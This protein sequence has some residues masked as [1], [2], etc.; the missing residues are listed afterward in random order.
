MPSQAPIPDGTPADISSLPTITYAGY[1]LWHTQRSFIYNRLI[2]AGIMYLILDFL[3]VFMTKDPYFI[4]GPDHP[5]LPHLPL[6]GYLQGLHPFF[7]RVYRQVFSLAGVLSAISGLFNLNDLAQYFL[8]SYI[9]PH[10]GDLWQHSS[11]FGSFHLVFDRGLAGWWGG[12]WHQ[13]FRA[14]FVAPAKWLVKQGYLES[15]S[16]AASVVALVVSFGQSGL[17]H[18][19]GSI[20]SVAE[21]KIW[22]SPLFFAL[23]TLGII[24]QT[25][26]AWFV[27]ERLHVSVPRRLAQA[28]NLAFTLTWLY[29]TADLFINDMA[30]AGIWLLEPVPF[31]FVRMC[32]FGF[33]GDRWWRWDEYHRPSWYTAQHWWQSGIAV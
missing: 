6:P 30:S 19:S 32:G 4:L 14:Q 16:V 20:S 1:R 15:G 13:T 11:T 5:S 10:R 24:T 22:R 2:T 21:T 31:S 29:F 3:A 33:P 12:W 9:I 25:T 23:Q 18:A 17:L 27:R 28:V 7:I 26:M 8:V